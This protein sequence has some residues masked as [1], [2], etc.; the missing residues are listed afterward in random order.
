MISDSVQAQYEAYPYPQREARDEAKRLITGSPSHLTEL[1]HWVFGGHIPTDRPF[2]ILV[3]GGGT[4]DGL[5]MLAQQTKDAGIP[6]EIDYVDLSTASRV[7]AEARIAARGLADRVTFKTG[8]LLDAPNWGPFDYIDCCGVLHHLPEPAQGFEALAK[9]LSPNGG[10]GLMVYGRYGRTGVYETQEALRLLSAVDEPL[11]KRIGLTKRYLRNAPASNRFLRNPQLGD[12][13][14]GGDAGLVDLLLHSVD[15]AYTVAALD[16]A[17]H[18]AGLRRVTYIDPAR[19]RPQTY[20]QEQD[21][22]KRV[23]QLSEADAARVAEAMAGNLAVHIAYVVR[24]DRMG[25]TT[26]PRVPEAIPVWRDDG[27]ARELAGLPA[28]VRSIP[29]I[30]DGLRLEM[31]YPA[32][33]RAFTSRIDGIKTLEEIRQDLPTKPDWAAFEKSISAAFATLTGFS[34]LFL[35]MPAASPPEA[36]RS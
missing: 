29:F 28:G 30:V 24:A 2:R 18:K 4:G 21:F 36:R 6:A 23:S 22:L 16:A 33:M 17:I 5:V 9:A 11:T 34:K 13:K 26:A 32:E 1:S 8:S 15:Q 35:R 31:P 10:M 14:S 20:A 12:H 7:K 19:Y 3:A 27:F 25:D